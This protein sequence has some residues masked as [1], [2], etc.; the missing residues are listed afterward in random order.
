MSKE[1]YYVNYYNESIS[2]K[3]KKVIEKNKL[4]KEFDVA[5]N[6]LKLNPEY[7]NKIQKSLWPEKYKK[8]KNI[9][10]LW[11][12]EISRRNPGWRMIYTIVKEGSKDKV[13]ILS[14]ILEV[15]NHHRYDRMFGY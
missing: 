11:R 8:I 10:N 14:V 12:Y 9:D 7:G 13:K 1:K 5:V 2:K 6:N 3:V 15:L 4:Q